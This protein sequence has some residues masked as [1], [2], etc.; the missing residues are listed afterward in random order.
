MSELLRYFTGRQEAM[1]DAL[2][3]MVTCESFTREKRYVDKMID[4]VQ[5]RFEDMQADSI[6]RYPQADVGDFLL[7]KVE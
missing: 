3:A 6:K 2:T 5:A 1:L 4:L 7:A